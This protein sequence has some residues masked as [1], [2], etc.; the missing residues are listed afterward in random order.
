MEGQESPVWYTLAL[1]DLVQPDMSL[2]ETFFTSSIDF[3]MSAISLAGPD[4]LS[5]I[6][7]LTEAVANIG[8]GKSLL[9]KMKD[10]QAYYEVGDTVTACSVLKGFIN[11]VD[12]Q[13]GKKVPEDDAELF[14][15]SA[16]FTMA[17]FECH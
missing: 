16:E 15:A 6:N 2:I 7:T 1:G 14:I 9:N 13:R 5:Q 4:P 8:P 11:E 12:A 17:T 10:V 3:D